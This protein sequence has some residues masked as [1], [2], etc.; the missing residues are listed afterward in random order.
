[1][2]GVC[3]SGVL[4][5]KIIYCTFHLPFNN[6]I[7]EGQNARNYMK[8]HILK[9]K[10]QNIVNDLFLSEQYTFARKKFVY[11]LGAR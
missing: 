10:I 11:V 4:I 1:M 8:F 6:I 3:L 2:S 5:R 9:L 7:L